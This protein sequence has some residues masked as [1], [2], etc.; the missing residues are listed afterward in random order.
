MGAQATASFGFAEA[1]HRYVRPLCREERDQLYQESTVSARLY[2]ALN[3]P[4]S[5]DERQHPFETMQARLEPSPIIFD[6][7]DIMRDAPILSS[8][9]LPLQ[10]IFIRAAVDLTP[11]SIKQ[12]LGRT[13][14]GLSPWEKPLVKLMGVVSNRI[15]LS[16]SAAVQSCLRLGLPVDYLYRSPG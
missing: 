5:D 10:R 13:A 12:K 6:F 8:V 9:F 3:T 14:Y 15:V 1:Y 7:L 4:A 11:I 2:G 16:S